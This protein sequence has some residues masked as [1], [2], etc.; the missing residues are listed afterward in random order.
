M[1]VYKPKYAIYM[2]VS[3]LGTVKSKLILHDSQVALY[4]YKVYFCKR[5]GKEF[6][7]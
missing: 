2:N 1:Y 4:L 6:N 7:V 3:I 5:R